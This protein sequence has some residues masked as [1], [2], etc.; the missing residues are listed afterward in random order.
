MDKNISNNVM[1]ENSQPQVF[2]QNQHPNIPIPHPPNE[3]NNHLNNKKILLISIIVISIIVGIGASIFL[4][5]NE[6]TKKKESTI[7]SLNISPTINSPLSFGKVNVSP[8][9]SSAQTNTP[10]ITQSNL[11]G[12][13]TYSSPEQGYGFQYLKLWQ[14]K[15]QGTAT[16]LVSPENQNSKDQTIALFGDVLVSS[17]PYAGPI[18]TPVPGVTAMVNP[19]FK[20][21]DDQIKDLANQMTVGNKIT[22]ITLKGLSGYE[23]PSTVAEGSTYNVILQGSKNMILIQFPNKKSRLDLNLGQTTVLES[24]AEL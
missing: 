18:G 21:H 13:S 3:L 16:S 5:I 10:I 22:P 20:S 4:G 23:A 19:P 15:K 24:I 17:I 14:V 8:N 1:Q 2:S 7:N 6:K 11:E 12:I 9:I